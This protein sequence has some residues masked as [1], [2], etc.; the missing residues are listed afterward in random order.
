MKTLIACLLSLI[1]ACQASAETYMV[2]VGINLYR[3]SV[4]GNLT[5]AERDAGAMAA[6]FSRATP[7]VT[8]LTG[9]RATKTNILSALRS[10]AARAGE[11]D[12]L[13]FFFSGH[14]FSGGFC[15][16]EMA[17]LADGLAY[18]EI[19]SVMKSSGARDKFIFADAC[20]SGAIRQE[21]SAG[22]PRPGNVLMFLS[23]RGRESS[24]E[25]PFLANGYFTKY[26]LRGLRGA[27]DI[28]RD[29]KITASEIFRFVSTGVAEQSA[30]RQHPVMWGSFPDDL[31]IVQYS[32]KK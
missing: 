4:I 22:N 2:S 19:I 14:G 17:S 28:D 23:S 24:L 13:I 21:G 18:D 25:S 3:S 12:R 32:R 10:H 7:F 26:L 15:P 9:C 30:D 29:R 8:T 27:A 16:Y 20:N 6:L 11:G 1:I 31:I 5:K